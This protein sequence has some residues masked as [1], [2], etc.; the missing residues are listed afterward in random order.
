MTEWQN[1]GGLSPAQPITPPG[2]QGDEQGSNSIPQK[3]NYGGMNPTDE[4]LS[5]ERDSVYI[6]KTTHE[7]VMPP[8]V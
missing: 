6:S 7:R 8:S 1:S 2:C 4:L 3:C 5:E